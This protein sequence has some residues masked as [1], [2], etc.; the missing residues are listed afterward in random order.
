MDIY[1]IVAST[2]AKLSL[3][4]EPDIRP[5]PKLLGDIDIDIDGDDFSFAF[6]PSLERALR[7]KTLQEDWDNVETIQDVV[8]ML[9]RKLNDQ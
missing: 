2:A 6:V 1:S 5:D 4:E 7:V 3:M 9:Q 8:H